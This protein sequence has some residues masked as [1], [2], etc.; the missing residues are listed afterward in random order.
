MN[1][2]LLLTFNAGSSTSATSC[3][4]RSGTLD[5]EYSRQLTEQLRQAGVPV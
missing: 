2:K 4:Q 3:R 5:P 1:D